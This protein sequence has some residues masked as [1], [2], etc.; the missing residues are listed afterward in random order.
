MYSDSPKAKRIEFRCPDASA[1]PY[2]AFAAMLMAGIDGIQK[3]LDAGEPADWDLFEEDRGVAQVP[4]SLAEALDALEHDHEFLHGGRRVQRGADPHLDRLQARERG[5]RR[6]AA[7]RIRPSSP[8][9]TTASRATMLELGARPS[10]TLAARPSA[11]LRALEPEDWRAVADDLLGR[12][13]RRPRHLRDGGA[14]L[15]GVGSPA[16]C[17]HHRLV[18]EIL[19]EVVGC[20]AL[21][22]VSAARCYAGV[23]EN[24]VYVARGA[25]GRGI[26]R[27]LLEALI[28]GA[29]GGRHLDDPDVDLPREPARRSRCT[30]AAA[31]ASSGVRERIASGTASG[32]TRCSSSD[33]ARRS[34]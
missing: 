13:A 8:S 9:T 21:A 17:E 25:R 28:D 20:A 4:G 14:V 32:G 33:E 15:G 31:S 16:T 5:R 22:P 12:D 7:A 11:E 1:N 19:G 24:S 3:G 34:R 30:S 23:V 27:A 29:R 2:L 26:G 10:D 18:A 6:A